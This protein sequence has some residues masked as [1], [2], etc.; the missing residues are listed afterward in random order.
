MESVYPL[1]R[2]AVFGGGPQMIGHVNT[3]QDEHIVVRIR[4]H[5][6]ADV[7]GELAV[8]GIDSARLQRA[9]EGTGQSATGGGRHVVDSRGVGIGHVG[10]HFVVLGDLA[11]DAE[12]H[13]L[14]LSG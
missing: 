3:P 5:L 10:A 1:D 9:P 12:R 14:A 11:V 2:I 7:S 6:A 4:L 8:A 13:G